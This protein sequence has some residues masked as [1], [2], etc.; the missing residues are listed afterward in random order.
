MRSPAARCLAA[1]WSGWEYRVLK[2]RER[3]A[4][5]RQLARSGPRQ[6]GSRKSSIV[7]SVNPT[8][9]LL[10]AARPPMRSPAARCICFDGCARDETGGRL[11]LALQHDS[12]KTRGRLRQHRGLGRNF[13]VVGGEAGPARPQVFVGV[14]SSADVWG[15]CSSDVWG[16]CSSARPLTSGHAARLGMRA[17]YPRWHR[18]FGA[19]SVVGGK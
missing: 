11:V 15:C 12:V 19:D 17:A 14:A 1:C 18:D 6:G 2:Q 10:I 5:E 8:P 16:C 13:A 4:G 7:E 3:R 9:G